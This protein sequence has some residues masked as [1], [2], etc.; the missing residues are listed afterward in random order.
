MVHVNY[1]K[2]ISLYYLPLIVQLPPMS[3]HFTPYHFSPVPFRTKK[4]AEEK[5]DEKDSDE[6]DEETSNIL[7]SWDTLSIV[8]S[9][10]RVLPFQESALQSK[11]SR[12]P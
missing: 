2:L 4:R 11:S 7:L 5:E 8:S 9:I 3:C 10:V 12:D 1:I 6:E